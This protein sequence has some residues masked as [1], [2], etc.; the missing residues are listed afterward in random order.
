MAQQVINVGSA[1]NDG[2]GDP[3]RS[4]LQ[5]A[6]ANFSELY[7]KGAAGS[8]LDISNN[9]ISIAEQSNTGGITLDPAGPNSLAG[10]VTVD[11]DVVKVAES[12]TVSSAVGSSGDEMGMIA[13]D[14]DYIYVCVADYD[15][16]SVI[17]RRSALSSW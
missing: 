10:V 5:K 14:A 8:N 15:G 7:A 13:W 3:L 4:A 1:P 11:D 9:D 17:W 12:R 2:T 16:S 6:N